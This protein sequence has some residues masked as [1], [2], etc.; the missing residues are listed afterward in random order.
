[1]SYSPSA[2]DGTRFVLSKQVCCCNVLSSMLLGACTPYRSR[3]RSRTHH[4][5]CS[6]N[7]NGSKQVIMA[8]GSCIP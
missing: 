7:T 8:S 2:F 6:K 3:S 1:M 4:D 5:A